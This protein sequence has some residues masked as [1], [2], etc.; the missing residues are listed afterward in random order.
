MTLRRSRDVNDVWLSSAQ[1]L[2]QI[3]KGVRQI[4]P[5]RQ[6][7]RHQRF[8]IADA[9]NSGIGNPLDLRDVRVGNLAATNY[10]DFKQLFAFCDSSQSKDPTPREQRSADASPAAFST[11]RWC[12]ESSSNKHA[13]ALG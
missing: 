9:D 5:F 7:A 6:L 2:V 1:E 13:T 12:N 11:F 4:K 10:A 3:V 8:L